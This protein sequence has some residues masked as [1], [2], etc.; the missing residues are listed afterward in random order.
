MLET[1]VVMGI[2]AIVA[3]A[4]LF[5]SMETYR[6]S[7]FR[8]DRDL[9]VAAL[10]RARAQAMSNIC[11]DDGGA[12]FT[13]TDGMPHGVKILPG[14]VIVFEGS[15]YAARTSAADAE[16]KTNVLSVSGAD[17]IV[18]AQL[19]GTTACGSGCTA[20]LSDGAGHISIATTTAVGRIYW[21]N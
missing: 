15:S 11:F 5:V 14:K 10:Q 3:G 1:V 4:A 9:L 6:G 7:N 21:S 2:F 13:C 19:S 20:I 8:S 17:E 18:F 12:T 16:F